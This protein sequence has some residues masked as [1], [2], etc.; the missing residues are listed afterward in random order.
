MQSQV[1]DRPLA[2][3][4]A[5]TPAGTGR[6]GRKT[7]VS[8]HRGVLVCLEMQRVKGCVPVENLTRLPGSHER[9]AGILLFRGRPVPLVSIRR[10]RGESRHH[11][12]KHDEHAIVVSAG[13]REFALRVDGVPMIAER[14]LQ[15]A[16]YADVPC[17]MR[18]KHLER[19]LALCVLSG[20]DSIDCSGVPDCRRAV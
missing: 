20:G 1:M 3:P 4:E 14:P 13:G 8:T 2:A 12:Q 6:L 5:G 17:V 10:D 9:V 18:A 15:Y 16:S 11:R 7:V 19:F